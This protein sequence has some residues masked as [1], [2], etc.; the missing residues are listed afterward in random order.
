MSVI[1][2][3]EGDGLI[4]RTT[5][6]AQ[7]VVI[8]MGSGFSSLGGKICIKNNL[9]EKARPHRYSIGGRVD[10]SYCLLTVLSYPEITFPWFLANI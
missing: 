9:L 10:K 5:G 6:D 8:V 7:I 4:V 3:D 2:K 1:E